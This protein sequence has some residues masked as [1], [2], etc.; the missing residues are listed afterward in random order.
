MDY[1]LSFGVGRQTAFRTEDISQSLPTEDDIPPATGAEDS[2]RHPFP[3]A[4]KMMFSYGPLI[5]MLNRGEGGADSEE[6]LAARA[7]SM[8]EYNM[9]PADMQW[10][11]GK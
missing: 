8:K 3:F 5:N 11:V 9:L 2:I 6:I 4:A 10:N 1:A 7:A